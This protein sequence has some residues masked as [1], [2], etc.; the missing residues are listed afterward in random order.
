MQ[1]FVEILRRRA[2]PLVVE[3]S[4]TIE[5]IR[6]KIQHKV[7]IPPHHQQL[8]YAGKILEGGCTLNHYN[9]QE[10][11][12]LYLVLLWGGKMMI[13]LIFCYTL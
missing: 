1:I 3:A 13:L 12:T 7:G 11:S 4:D 6:A 5:F 10:G 8:F 9:I 2:I